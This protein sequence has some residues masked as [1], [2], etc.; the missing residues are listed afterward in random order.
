M[1]AASALR[2]PA[3]RTGLWIVG[4][5]LCCAV[6]I[7]VYEYF[8]RSDSGQWV[9]Y[10]MLDA[11]ANRVDSLSARGFDLWWLSPVIIALPAVFFL[12]IVLTRQRFLAALIALGA[13]LGANISTQVLKAWLDRPDLGNGVPYW[14]GNS[15]PSGHTTLA[16]SMAVAVFLVSSP[17]RRPFIS[18]LAA[19]Y[20][21]LI[22][23]YTFTETWHRPADVIAA[24]LV[25]AI[26][27]MVGGWLIMRTGPEWNT[28]VADYEP[29]TAPLAGL[30]WFLGVS[31]TVVAM[32][33][34]LLSGGWSG[35]ALAGEE[36][37]L[38]HWFAGLLVSLGPGFLMAAAGINLF[39]AETGRRQRGAPVPSPKGETV[40]YPIPPQFN[41]LYQ[42]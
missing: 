10:A 1:S 18:V 25:V 36:P 26:W 38:W 31:I 4:I 23:A 7:A 9:E 40:H 11:A 19:F 27:A 12:V 35:I 37:S 14:T 24:Y 39:G 5:L 15:L 20:A 32:L 8:V 33:S 21:G 34:F 3:R 17:R 42:V 13:V 16:A 28:V 6:F 30:A 29:E 22:G 2:P 41:E